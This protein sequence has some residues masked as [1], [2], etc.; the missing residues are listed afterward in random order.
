MLSIVENSILEQWYIYSQSLKLLS[1]PRVNRSCTCERNMHVTVPLLVNGSCKCEQDLKLS[2]AS[3]HVNRTIAQGNKHEIH[4][5]ISIYHDIPHQALSYTMPCPSTHTTY[6]AIPL[7]AMPCHARQAISYTMPY[8]ARPYHMPC[9]A[10]Q[11]I[12]YTMPNL[13]RPYHMYLYFWQG[14]TIYRAIP[15]QAIRYAMSCP[16]DHTMSYP[17]RQ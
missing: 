16:T 7:H 15:R 6:H 13:A 1:L 10:Q 5:S 8:L 12:S 14:H 4:I 2:S 11:A 9:H 17:T 3:P